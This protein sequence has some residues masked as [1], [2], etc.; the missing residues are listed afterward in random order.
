MKG[1]QNN[2]AGG[3]ESGGDSD[4]ARRAGGIFLLFITLFSLCSYLS[5]IF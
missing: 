4:K 2:G 5:A 1:S 3:G